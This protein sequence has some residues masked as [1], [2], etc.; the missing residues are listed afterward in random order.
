MTGVAIEWA[1]VDLDS[2]IAW[3]RQLPGAAE[4]KTLLLAAANEAAR[5]DPM[6]A[7][8]IAVT[9]PADGERNE[10]I[11]RA[12]TEWTSHDATSAVDWAK[13]IP[14]EILRS[15]VLAAEAVAWSE[16]KPESAATL[17]VENLPTGRLLD[18]TVVSIVQRWA[19]RQPEAAAAWVEQFPEGTLRVTAMENL[20]AQ[21]SPADTTDPQ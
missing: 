3:A 5:T 1:N 8:R 17:A 7:L 10:T 2:T 18:D 13:Q 14:D 20:I 9:L 12:A 6:A 21:A 16:S 11:R 19:Q 4:Q 15:Q